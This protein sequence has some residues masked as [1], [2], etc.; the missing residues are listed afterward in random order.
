MEKAGILSCFAGG[1]CLYNFDTVEYG[2]MLLELLFRSCKS[3]C[4]SINVLKHTFVLQI[5]RPVE[6]K[7][8]HLGTGGRFPS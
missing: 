7:E 6:G 5:F 8:K 3:V 1:F 4:I 2:R